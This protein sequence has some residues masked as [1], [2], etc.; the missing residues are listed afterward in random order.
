VGRLLYDEGFAGKVDALGQAIDNFARIMEAIDTEQGAVGELLREDGAGQQALLDLREATGSLRRFSSGLESTDT[1]VG[2]LVNDEE[3]GEALATDLK[4][5]VANL[6]EI[7]DK[8][9]RGHG[10]V[11]AL[12]NDRTVYTGMEQVVAGVNDSKF[13]R[14]LMRRYQKKGIKAEAEASEVE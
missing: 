12:V 4:S 7:T 2:R 8:I 10:T 5:V 11:G 1:F 14:W 9:N 13:S 3:Y 6:A